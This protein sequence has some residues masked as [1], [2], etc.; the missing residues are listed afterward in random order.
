MSRTFS[1]AVLIAC[2]AGALLAMASWQGVGLTDV[3]HFGTPRNSVMVG[4]REVT[5]PLPD[6]SAQRR[7]AIVVPQ[8]TGSYE[9]LFD[10]AGAAPVRYDP[11]RPIPWV[12][13][14][15][16]MP[17]DAEPLLHAAVDRV[18]EA[19]GLELVYEGTTAEPADFGRALVQPRY[20]DRF[21]PVVI[22]WSTAAQNPDLKG[23][24]T[25]VG[26]SSAVNGAYGDQRYL[27]AGVII[28]DS[29]DMSTL[30]VGAGGQALAQAIVMHEWGH[31]LGLAHVSDAGE[32]MNASNT[33]LTSWGPGDLEGLALAGSG[34]CEEV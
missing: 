1:I 32:L 34:H 17:T 26:G 15:E 20:G 11:C 9:F 14:P 28:L 12:L 30:M 7:R 24:V 31:V 4:D 27:H 18:S 16:G 19:S 2:G 8:S 33:A 13:S 25:G 29:Q 10:D 22:G 23:A 5:I 3:Q 21:A 6:G